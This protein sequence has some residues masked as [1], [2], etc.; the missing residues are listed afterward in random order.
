[1]TL[2]SIKVGPYRYTVRVV[3]DLRHPSHNSRLYGHWS[4]EEHTLAIRAGETPERTL[5]IFL[6]EL[7]HAIDE[8]VDLGLSE[9]QV[10]RLGTMLAGALLDNDLVTIPLDLPAATDQ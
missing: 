7:L 10:L 3:R 1:M 9:K 4:N 2:D 8:A 6:H 5:A